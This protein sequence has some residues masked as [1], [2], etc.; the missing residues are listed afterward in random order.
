M[1]LINDITSFAASAVRLG[2]GINP[3]V[4]RTRPQEPKRPLE[5]YDFEACPYCR[6]VREALCEL[7]LDYLEHPVAKGSPRRKEL[8]RRGGKVQVPYLVDP[9][10]DTEL[11][12]S[13]DII[14]Y[15]NRTY[16]DGKRAGWMLPVPTVVDD[17]ISSLASAA[18]FGRGVTCRAQGHDRPKQ[19]LTLYNME[20]SPYC[21]KVREVLCELDLVYAVR[22][23]AKGSPKRAEL[24]RRGGKV[25]VPYLIDPNT[26]TEMYESDDIVDYLEEH[27]GGARERRT[28]DHRAAQR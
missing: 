3:V 15:L 6:K 26:K 5:L 18:R 12:E 11:Y 21:R 22:N 14:D 28:R 19:A 7:D 25:Q 23:V 13:D 20:G 4:T 10:T 27:Y 8:E 17:L 16:G 9:N 2:R 24:Q 1:A